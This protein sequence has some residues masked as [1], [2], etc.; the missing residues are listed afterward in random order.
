MKNV[1]IFFGTVLLSAL[2]T[3]CGPA[4]NNAANTTVRTNAN[5]NVNANANTGVANSI[6][7]A[8]AKVMTDSPDEFMIAAAEGGMV[9]VETSKAILPKTQNAE[10]KKFAQMMVSDHTK[11]GA[12]LKALAAKKN[13]TLPPDAGSRKDDI[14][15]FKKTDAADWDAT[16]V[17]MM[18]DDHESTVEAFEEQA[19]GS[20]DPD[21]KAF[22]AKTLPTLKGHLEQIKAIQAKLP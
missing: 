9:E 18:V 1:T 13:V 7:N 14:D 3:G 16:Y 15:G 22:A 12:E 19:A 11:A 2:F 17:D 4:A 6:A 10:I 8:A 21:V 20:S 5:S